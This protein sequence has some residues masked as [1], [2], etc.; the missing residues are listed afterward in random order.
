MYDTW[1]SIAL[2]LAHHCICLSLSFII[3]TGTKLSCVLF[4][5]SRGLIYMTDQ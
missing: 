5:Y 4:S 2:D 3:H 1:H